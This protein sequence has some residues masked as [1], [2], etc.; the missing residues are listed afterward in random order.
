MRLL[1]VFCLDADT[2]ADEAG[3]SSHSA[4]GL[5]RIV[6]LGASLPQRHVAVETRPSAVTSA[7]HGEEWRE[8][9]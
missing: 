9:P 6:D 7:M 4:R 8:V 5:S 1:R 2:V 3:C